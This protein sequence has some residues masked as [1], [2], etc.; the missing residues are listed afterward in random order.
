MEAVDGPRS[1]S[2]APPMSI[3]GGEMEVEERALPVEAADASFGPAPNEQM[4][5]FAVEGLAILAQFHGI[6]ADPV[7]IR[8]AADSVTVRNWFTSE[9][10]TDAYIENVRFAD[11]TAWD[12]AKLKS[13]PIA[14][15]STDTG[16][17]QQGWGGNDVLNGGAGVDSLIGGAGDDKLY[18]GAGND[19]Y[20]FNLGDGDDSIAERGGNDVVRFGE[21]IATDQIWL[22]KVG[23]NLEVSVIGRDQTET[24]NGW[25]TS[26]SNRIESFVTSDGHAMAASAVD[27]LV[28]AMAGFAPP[29]NGQLTLSDEYRSQ[30]G[31]SI[32]A[33]WS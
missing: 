31:T 2:A 5:D 20:V 10:N 12:L 25:Y 18:G 16:G 6:A 14:S 4:R 7:Q 29:A 17:V 11:G 8:H 13:M 21:G 26:T 9:N 22:R 15:E 28:S 32:A 3:N 1:R 27:A 24:I 23:S 33:S 30:L 19:S